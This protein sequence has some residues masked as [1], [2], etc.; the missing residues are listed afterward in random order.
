MTRER[1]EIERE[2][3]GQ[4]TISP[5]KSW[6]KFLPR[7][8][9]DYHFT[10]QVM[11]Y[12]SAAEGSKS[13]GFFNGRAASVIEFNRFDPERVRTYEVGLRSDWL[14]KR[15]RLN[16]TAFYSDYTDMQIQINASIMHRRAGPCRSTSSVT[17]RRRRS[18]AASSSSRS[19]R[20][21]D[22]A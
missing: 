2:Q 12:V 20:W 9:L 22:L 1:K 14:E 10:P 5:H 11:G 4:V 15:L 21:R 16:A 13:G 18:R 8:G 17:F 3:N 7:L 19:F 6:T